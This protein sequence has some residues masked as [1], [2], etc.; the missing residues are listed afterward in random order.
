MIEG[1]NSALIIVDVQNDFCPGGK[2]A[3]NEGDQVVEPINKMIRFARE[4]GMPVIATRDFHPM[5]TSH[6]ADYGGDWPEHCVQGTEGVK[7]HPK[8]EIDDRTVVF[9]KGMGDK[10]NAYSG[11][12]GRTDQGLTLDQF[13]KNHRIE[14][15][16]VAGLATDY[17]VKATAIDAAKRGLRTYLVTDAIKAVNVKA[18][19]GEIALNEMKEAGVEFTTSE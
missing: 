14:K 17:C 6:F 9:S 18:D 11:F 12:D 3:V 13:L 1:E 19:D 5:Q 4:N 7:F 10:E 8:L 15:V 2:L 16:Y